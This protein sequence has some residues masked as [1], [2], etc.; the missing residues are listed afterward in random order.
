MQG[1]FPKFTQL[2]KRKMQTQT[3][4]ALHHC[5]IPHLNKNVLNELIKFHADLERVKVSAAT[6]LSEPDKKMHEKQ[7]AQL[8]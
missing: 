2:Q 8:K 4:G 5:A 1:N 7:G 6:D 3:V